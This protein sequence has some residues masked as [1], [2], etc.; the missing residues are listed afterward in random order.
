ME[1]PASWPLREITLPAGVVVEAF[2][3]SAGESA[4]DLK[5]YSVFFS[6]PESANEVIEYFEEQTKKAGMKEIE[7]QEI[8]P[9]GPQ[10]AR[11]IDWVDSTNKWVVS[12]RY[13]KSMEPYPFQ[14]SVTPFER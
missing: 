2:K 7:R 13:W 14:L 1:T 4:S 9:G 6:Y 11:R 10:D 5:S 3:P 12:I 8:D